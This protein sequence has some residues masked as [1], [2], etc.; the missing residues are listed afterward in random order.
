MAR[1]HFA[2]GYLLN[3][4]NFLKKFKKTLALLAELRYNRTS[5][6][7]IC[8]NRIRKTHVNLHKFLLDKISNYDYNVICA[9]MAEWQTRMVQVHVIAI[10]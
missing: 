3:C 9:G 8:V 6:R 10:S 4:I 2:T 5:V 1:G 7:T